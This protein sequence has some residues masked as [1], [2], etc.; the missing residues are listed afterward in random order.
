MED[1]NDYMRKIRN[2]QYFDEINAQNLNKKKKKKKLI[3]KGNS[4][5]FAS[6]KID[7][8]SISF[9]PEGYEFISY[10]AYIILLPYIVGNSFL[11]LVISPP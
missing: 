1:S 10:M 6:Q 7:F 4:N 3:S 5:T 2:Q 9:V 11:F 8:S